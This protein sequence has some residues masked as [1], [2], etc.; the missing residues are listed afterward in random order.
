MNAKQGSA[1]RER[2]YAM[3]S[4]LAAMTLLVL[5]LTAAV[6]PV[7]H[8]MQ[9]E[10][11]EEMLWRG[12][13]VAAAVWKYHSIRAGAAGGADLNPAFLPTK[14]EE[15]A[16]AYDIN[17][18]KRYLV[19]RSALRDPMTG[20]GEWKAVRIG[21]PLVGEL[22]RAYE[23]YVVEQSRNAAGAGEQLQRLTATLDLL[24]KAAI[25]SGVQ[26]KGPGGNQSGDGA[27]D[28]AP[29]DSALRPGSAFSLN[30]ESRP[31]IG[32]VSRSKEKLIRSYFG[33]ESYDR[34]MFFPGVSTSS[35]IVVFGFGG[36]SV[37]LPADFVPAPSKIDDLCRCQRD[38]TTGRC[39]C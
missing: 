39:L 7:R 17:G 2:G 28:S 37:Q 12:T 36:N 5:A 22:Y 1:R 9:R 10:K 15:L 3:L 33:L 31:I 38:R 32:V 6:E 27:D 24:R 4:L 23:K 16:E 25:M 13:Q 35:V 18:Q 8:R 30:P 20:D 21:D 11:E 26:I 14:L 29:S 19:R 34:A